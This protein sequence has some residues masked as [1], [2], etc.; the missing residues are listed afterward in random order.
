V[1]QTVFPGPER[2]GYA[3]WAHLRRLGI[4][5]AG[6]SSAP[7][8]RPLRIARPF[9]AGTGIFICLL[10]TFCLSAQSRPTPKKPAKPFRV[11][12]YL[13]EYRAAALDS[14]NLAAV[15][16]LLFFSLEPTP[17]G[18]LDSA[19]LT[20]AIIAKLQAVKR[21]R[22]LRL[23]VTV[24][25]WDRSA[26]FAPMTSDPI[27]R[28]KFV[29]TLTQFCLSHHFDGADFD[30]EH[31]A[32]AAEEAGYAALLADVRLAFLPH[33]LG[34]SVTIAPWQKLAPQAVAAVDSVQVM[35]Y[36]HDGPHS[37]LAQAEADIADLH[38]QGIPWN[39]L[40]LGIPLYGRGL[41]QHNTTETYADIWTRFH[42]APAIDEAGELYFNGPETVQQKTRYAL[43]HH[44]DGVMV[45]EIGQD[46]PGANSLLKAIHQ[47]TTASSR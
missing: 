43:A 24:G 44:L 21:R 31:P 16:D 29:Q 37:T 15:T 32:N 20:P 41:A 2:P 5:I 7:K 28:R 35:S 30:W 42:P 23:W 40:C 33:R 12:A 27:K 22:P 45:W 4:V 46:A 14:A 10:L 25:G 8:G 39:K 38:Q 18:G 34:L 13:P 11:V 6:R 26:G 17:A 3:A 19:R 1:T 9:R 36:D 47:A